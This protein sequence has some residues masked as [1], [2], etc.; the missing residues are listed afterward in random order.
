MSMREKNANKDSPKQLNIKIV[1]TNLQFS[2]N[3]VVNALKSIHL[4]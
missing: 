3:T 1:T 2:N 4:Q